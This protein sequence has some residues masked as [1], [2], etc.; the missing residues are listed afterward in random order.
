MTSTQ[1]RNVVQ[2]LFPSLPIAPRAPD[3]DYAP[4]FQAARDAGFSCQ[5]Y[6]LEALRAQDVRAALKACRPA[7]QPDTPI[8]YR[9]WMLRDT[10]Y[11]DL[12]AGLIDRGYRPLTTPAAYA[13]AHYLPLAYEKLRGATPESVWM[14]GADP[15]AAW[16][17]YQQV[18]DRPA[19]LKD[20]VKSAKHRWHAACFL[21]AHT[22]RAEFA[23]ILSAFLRERGGLFEHGLVLR[24]YHPLV[25]LGEQMQG[26]PIHEEYRLF[27]YAGRIIA[28]APFR[29]PAAL[30]QQRPSWEALAAT[31]S[32]RFITL[33][34]ARQTDDS[35]IVVEVGDAGVSGLPLSIDPATFYPALWRALHA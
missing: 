34:V 35:W 31:F 33:D 7:P 11:A 2:I 8:L 26:Q 9:G 13:E 15:E 20:Y 30:Q 6:E 17:L 29:D 4:E 28:H 5:L 16:Q 22:G 12:Y 10:H 25:Q 32:N 21:P 19:I 18:A 27:C 1:E 3:P 23:A 14:L 24:R